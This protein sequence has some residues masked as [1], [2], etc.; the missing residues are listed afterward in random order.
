M[1][2]AFQASKHI[3]AEFLVV[4]LDDRFRYLLNA[5]RG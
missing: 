1:Q 4:L 5:R 2:R 3:V